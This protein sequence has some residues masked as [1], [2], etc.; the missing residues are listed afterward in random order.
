[1]TATATTQPAATMIPAAG[2]T[3]EEINAL[4][5]H[6]GNKKLTDGQRYGSLDKLLKLNAPRICQA[7][8]K[9]LNVDRMMRVL[10]S[11][12]RKNKKLLLCSIPSVLGSMTEAATMGWEIGGPLGHAYL[13]PF[14]TK[15]GYECQLIPG[16]KGLLDLCRRSGQIST[17]ALEVV[18]EGDV[19]EYS[20]GDD[21]KIVHRPNEKDA[22]REAKAITHAY[23]VVKLRDG[24]VQRSVWGSD[25]IN[26]HKEQYSEGWKWAESGDK[27]KGGGGKDSPWHTAWQ[28]M[29]KKTVVR[30]MINRGLLPVSPEHQAMVNRAM[31][32]DIDEAPRGDFEF[33]TIDAVPTLSMDDTAGALEGDIADE[34]AGTTGDATGD[35]TGAG[36][37][38]GELP[39]ADAVPTPEWIDQLRRQLDNVVDE[40]GVDFVC[41]PLLNEA[42]N[43]PTKEIIARL[44]HDRKAA[45][46]KAEE[47]HEQPTKASKGKQR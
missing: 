39:A 21:P 24:G 12:V 41:E 15:T 22:G 5:H 16:Y 19:F 44:A 27:G 4:V 23:C 36:D 10:M 2:A 20:L 33:S 29:A 30:D 1:M 3:Q 31:L 7:L 25:R 35:A 18:H 14:Y 26:A 6:V 34:G 43:D 11:A 9:H 37:T 17:I 38:A 40:V 46:R 47:A 13:V 28:T 32:K 42:P 8:P 45:I